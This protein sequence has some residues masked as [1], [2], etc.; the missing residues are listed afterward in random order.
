M[1]AVN[2]SDRL[3]MEHRELV[4]AIC[5]IEKHRKCVPLTYSSKLVLALMLW[6]PQHLHRSE[7]INIDQL[8]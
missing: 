7:S 4:Y 3:P 6:S 8:G 5:S 2:G 1:P